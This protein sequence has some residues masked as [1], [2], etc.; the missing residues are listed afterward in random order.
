MN[1]DTG[2]T[3]DISIRLELNDQFTPAYRDAIA[4]F[5]VGIVP[6]NDLGPLNPI[7]IPFG[8]DRLRVNSTF[9]EAERTYINIPARENDEEFYVI[10]VSMS[11][12][13]LDGCQVCVTILSYPICV[14]YMCTPVGIIVYYHLNTLRFLLS[15]CLSVTDVGVAI[16]N[17]RVMCKTITCVSA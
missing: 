9:L 2:N 1:I 4:Y 14:S 11:F 12:M 6:Y 3:Y 13:I 16:T 17:L 15:V 5:L 10:F 8:E 7:R